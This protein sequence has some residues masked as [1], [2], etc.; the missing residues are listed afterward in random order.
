MR[1]RVLRGLGGRVGPFRAFTS[2]GPTPT[3]AAAQPAASAP[4]GDLAEQ[5][6][7]FNPPAVPPQLPSFPDSGYEENKRGFSTRLGSYG[8]ALKENPVPDPAG[9]AGSFSGGLII[10]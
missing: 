7:P 8:R 6:R 10:T 3:A 1:F 9:T 4:A 2:S 5:A